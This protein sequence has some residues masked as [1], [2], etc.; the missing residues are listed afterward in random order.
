MSQLFPAP[1]IRPFERLQAADGLLINA[2]RW[3]R[4]H[5]YH[6]LRQ[7]MHYQAL[8]QPG[9]VCGLGV[10]A[11]PAPSEVKAEYRDGR[12]VRIQPGIAIDLVGNPIVVP[13]PI[14]F[15]VAVEL[16]DNEPAMVYLVV[17]Y[18][19]PDDLRREER[20]DIVQETFRVDEKS[21]PP[22]ELEV[23]VCRVLLQPGTVQLE[24]PR[25]VFFP[26]YS[27]VDLRFRLQAQP[28]PQALISMAVVNHPDPDGTRHFFNL[29]HLL[30]ATGALYPALQG[31]GEV[32]QV[33][34][35]EAEGLEA[36]DLLYL[37]G[38]QPLVLNSREFEALKGYLDRGGVLMVDAPA[39]AAPLV[40]SVLAL[41]Q[42]LET[43]LEYLE[44]LRRDHPLRTHPFLFSAL[45]AINQ[46]PLRLLTGGGIVLTIG[47]LAAAWGIDDNFALSRLAIRT[48]HEL[49]INILAYAW[50]RRQ[51][52][53]LQGKDT[54]W[55]G[56][57]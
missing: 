46:Q 53:A 7:G 33:S 6:R 32:G 55:M 38:R 5:E 16:A 19:D 37:T 34:F 35:D 51:L 21:S 47:E 49:G 18:V 57:T 31:V 42:Q 50:R 23:E 39:D 45:P 54:A 11:I 25:E 10:Q 28:R 24:N 52:F 17:K 1:P 4:A 12:W 13:Q 14:D 44:R 48:A 2:E 8:N 26:G 27:N 9:I 56:G 22:E 30:R 36:H 43:P 15:R 40:E 41:A 20:R 29:P 3:R